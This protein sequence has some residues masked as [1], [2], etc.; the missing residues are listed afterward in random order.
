MSCKPLVQVDPKTLT[1]SIKECAESL[2][3]V[4]VL[5]PE[6]RRLHPVEV[7]YILYRD[8]AVVKIGE[9]SVTFREF[10]TLYS[11]INPMALPFFE[12]YYELRRR[13]K[14]PI[15][16]PRENT[17]VLIRSRRNPKQTHYILVVEEG[18]PVPIKLLQSFVEEARHRGLEPV[19]AIVDRYGDV[20]FYT[21]MVFHPAERPRELEESLEAQD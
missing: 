6:G 5:V 9:K 4:V 13:G 7:A 3:R 16:G 11:R 8:A 14:L 10:M 21:P 1:G 18:R 17:L 19:L 2:G 12:V 20:T 15:P